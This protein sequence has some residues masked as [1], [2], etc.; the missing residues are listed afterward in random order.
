MGKFIISSI[1]LFS[2]GGNI[3][4]IFNILNRDLD[5]VFKSR[6]TIFTFLLAI[7]SFIATIFAGFYFKEVWEKSGE[8]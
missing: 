2:A 5:I 1:L 3:Y 4:V 6:E 8:N 7:A